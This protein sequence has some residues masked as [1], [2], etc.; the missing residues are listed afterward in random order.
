MARKPE[1]YLTDTIETWRQ[2]SNK[3]SSIVGEPDDLETTNKTNLVSSINEVRQSSGQSFI[4]NQLSV[5]STG[6]G[7]YAS[8]SYNQNSGTFTFTANNLQAS[9]IPSID[10]SKVS[11]GVFNASQI[12]SLDASKI[13]TG[14]IDIE[15]LPQT[16]RDA[17][18]GYYGTYQPQSA[19]VYGDS[20]SKSNLNKVISVTGDE[21]L[22]IFDWYID[23]LSRNPDRAGFEF[24]LNVYKNIGESAAKAEFLS[25]A[26]Y[27]DEVARGGATWQTFCEFTDGD[28]DCVDPDIQTFTSDITT[29]DDVPEGSN[30]LYFTTTRARQSISAGSN[31]TYNPSTGVISASFSGIDLSDIRVDG[32]YDEPTDRTNNW[33]AHSLQSLYLFL[34]TNNS[35][36][37]NYFAIYNNLDPYIHP[38]S[39]DNSIFRIDETGDVRVT[40]SISWP[41]NL[42][43]GTGDTAR[44]YVENQ[45]S[46]EG[47]QL[48]LEV[49]N[50]GADQIHFKAPSDNGVKINGYTVIHEGNI[51]GSTASPNAP[52]ISEVFIEIPQHS[53]V[54]Y[55]TSDMY[56]DNIARPPDD[57]EIILVCRNSEA[58]YS[59]GDEIYYGQESDV[60]GLEEGVVVTRHAS[61]QLVQLRIGQA[62]IGQVTGKLDGTGYVLK[63]PNWSIKVRFKWWGSDGNYVRYKTN[64]SSSSG[65]GSPVTVEGNVTGNEAITLP[66]NYAFGNINVAGQTTITANDNSDNLNIIAGSNITITTNGSDSLTINAVGSSAIGVGQSWVDVTSS[67]SSGVANQNLT[68]KPI[69][70]SAMLVPYVV[71]STVTNSTLEVGVTIGGVLNWMRVA[72]SGSAT[73]FGSPTVISMNSSTIIPPNHYYRY[74]GQVE[75]IAELR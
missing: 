64:W 53:G 16:V 67:R 40:G 4:R 17:A 75:A 55:F 6:G 24:W 63:S 21:G 46:A 25:S 47:T 48:T 36:D 20:T 29:T 9:D 69:T 60:H 54:Y 22:T 15:R 34:D 33:A 42:Y 57:H 52:I 14:V 23:E 19:L 8:L 72:S 11:T 26:E 5:I 56:P 32:D 27:I 37:N 58:G 3:L 2:K 62:G 49:T 12:P 73:G 65:V 38:V 71:G 70:V 35:E 30:N 61:S 7:N 68:G 45:D 18:A 10:A 66:A 1:V 50:D 44:I 51:G 13:S 31:I 39:R 43:G 41:E 74:I 28:S 59:V